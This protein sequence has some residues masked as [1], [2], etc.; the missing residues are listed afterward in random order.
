MS[1]T[2]NCQTLYTQQEICIETFNSSRLINIFFTNE[3]EK[4]YVREKIL[5]CIQVFSNYFQK[6]VMLRSTFTNSISFSM[7]TR[8]HLNEEFG[9]DDI[10][11]NERKNK[12]ILFDP[13]LDSAM[14]WFCW[15]MLSLNDLEKTI[16]MHWVLESSAYCFF[17]HAKEIFDRYRQMEYFKIHTQAD[18]EQKK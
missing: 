8:T 13:V 4:E 15:K 14:A 7:M 16:L 9:H 2:D 5:D 6:I 11:L 17:T 18:E 3:M 12:N 10:L 1:T